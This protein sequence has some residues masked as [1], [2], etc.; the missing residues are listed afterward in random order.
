M[1]P[2]EWCVVVLAVC[3]WLEFFVILAL[4]LEVQRLERE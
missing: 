2:V 3:V 4:A 1:T